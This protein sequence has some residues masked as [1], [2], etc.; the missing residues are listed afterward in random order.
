MTMINTIKYGL[1]IPEFFRFDIKELVCDHVYRKY[2]N[3]AWR[4]YKQHAIDF[5]HW[6][7][8]EINKPIFINTYSLGGEY[9]QSGLRC[10]Q[11]GIVQDQI[12]DDNVYVSAH[13][14]GVGWDPRVTGMTTGQVHDWFYENEDK[15]PSPIR[16]ELGVPHLHVDLDSFPEQHRKI[17]TFMV[18]D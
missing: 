7:R 14:R 8:T 4:F 6:F 5:L 18:G 10:I 9:T 16:L 11:C 17:M 1:V 3:N 2:G 13:L 12:K 15:L